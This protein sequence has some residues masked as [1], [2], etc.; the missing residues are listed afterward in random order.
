[1]TDLTPKQRL[2]CATYEENGHNGTAAAIAAGYSE[3]T[4]AVTASKLLKKPKIREYRAALVRDMLDS[5]V[6]TPERIAL[7]KEKIYADSVHKD[8]AKLA[9]K[10][11][12]SIEKSMTVREE[13]E[14]TRIEISVEVAE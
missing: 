13:K 1:M 3:K 7:R 6:L 8:R 14:D 4:A 12:E 11:L 5:A 10:A 2:F 9:L